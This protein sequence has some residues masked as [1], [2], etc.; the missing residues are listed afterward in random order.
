MDRPQYLLDANIFIEAAKRYY[1]FDIA[2]GFWRK[3]EQLAEESRVCSVDRVQRE[4]MKSNDQLATWAKKQFST[5]FLATDEPE[6]VTEYQ[7]VMRWVSAQGQFFDA[8]KDEFASGADGWLIAYAKARAYVVVTD[9]LLNPSI[10]RRVPN[11]NVCH[12]FGVRCVNTFGMLREL[13]VSFS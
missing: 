3:L 12:A 9:E 1:A 5:A 2:P 6:V 10:K 8:A 7:Q 4:L 11:P 13:W